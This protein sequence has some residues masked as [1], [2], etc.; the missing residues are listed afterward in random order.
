MNTTNVD[1]LR[2]AVVET[3]E[4]GLLSASKWYTRHDHDTHELI[5]ESSQH[6]AAEM[7]AGIKSSLKTPATKSV[8]TNPSKY[9][10]LRPKSPPPPPPEPHFMT[11][12]SPPTDIIS[13]AQLKLG[14]KQQE[15]IPSSER[16]GMAELAVRK[17]K[18]LDVPV[19]QQE[20]DAYAVARR[21]FDSKEF[22][23]VAFT[24]IG[25][26]TAQSRFLSYYSQ[27]LVG[28]ASLAL[29]NS[30]LWLGSRKASFECILQTRQYVHSVLLNGRHIFT[31]I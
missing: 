4:R 5:S 3:S 9:P 20:K 17:V 26:K 1:S 30:R 2:S 19:S 6:R 11:S 15:S 7:L 27:Y 8:A 23:R 21:F 14:A 25:H 12:S 10:T 18:V 22:D 28:Y 31:Y 13:S 29:V 16:A 24:L